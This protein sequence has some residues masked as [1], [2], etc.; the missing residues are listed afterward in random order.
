MF[1]PPTALLTSLVLNTTYDF[2]H[3]RALRFTLVTAFL[4]HPGTE[5][6]F[7]IG[8]VI[9][10]PL[11]RRGRPIYLQTAAIFGYAVIPPPGRCGFRSS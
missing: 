10:T 7:P 5:P 4:N 11:L 1:W 3:G 9:L 6:L 8:T 2:Q